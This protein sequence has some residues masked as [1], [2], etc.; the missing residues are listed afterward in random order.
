M[1]RSGP[2]S[3]HFKADRDQQG[4]GGLQR[5]RAEEAVRDRQGHHADVHVS[6]FD[7]NLI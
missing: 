1:G 2:S 6:I 3:W 5:L 7:R 4:H